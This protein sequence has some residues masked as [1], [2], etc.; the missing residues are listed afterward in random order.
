MTKLKTVTESASNSSISSNQT[1]A[2]IAAILT[3][4]PH[5]FTFPTFLIVAFTVTF[6][7]IIL[8]VI[9][10]NLFRFLFRLINRYL[11]LW[12]VMLLG[13]CFVFNVVICVYP[14]SNIVQYIAVAGFG[15]PQVMFVV[16]LLYR[17]DFNRK[18]WIAYA[19]TLFIAL[20]FDLSTFLLVGKFFFYSGPF[21]NLSATLAV[22]CLAMFMFTE[23]IW[24]MSGT[25]A[26][27]SR[28]K[29]L[30]KPIVTEAFVS[31]R[32]QLTWTFV[33][34]WVGLN[35]GL[36]FA[37]DTLL[38]SVAGHSVILG[39][40]GI[41]K[42]LM[43]RQTHEKWKK[44]LSYLVVIIGS[45][46]LDVKATGGLCLS[47]VP[48]LYLIGLRFRQDGQTFIRKYFPDWMN[49]WKSRSQSTPRIDNAEV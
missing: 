13:L 41:G 22:I 8:P 27:I 16:L 37:P 46:F 21:L 40:Y 9:A 11:V 4:G 23:Q 17:T 2:I 18:R 15:L 1:D 48:L 45:A 47:T 5:L 34:V 33:A 26:R 36:Y 20:A 25:P 6:L 35:V 42:I 10:G 39:L 29:A 43:A 38:L 31:H 3:S 32:K 28:R 19:G 30:L 24:T 12:R 7:T 49:R 14:S 44:W